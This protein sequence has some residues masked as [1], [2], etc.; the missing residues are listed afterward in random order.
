MGLKADLNDNLSGTL[1]LFDLT[2]TNVLTDDPENEGFSIQTGEQKSQGIEVSLN[3]ELKPGW[4]IFAGYTYTDA[5]VSQ[6]NRIP[7][8]NRLRNAPSNAFNIW[9]T[10]Q[11]Q[12]GNFDGLGFGFGVFYVGEREGDLANTFQLPSY[13]RT[14][15]AIYFE[16]SDLRAGLNFKNLFDVEYYESSF[17]GV[18]VFPGAPFTMEGNLSWQF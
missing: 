3:G 16:R 5:T 17:G 15:A 18:G 7:V 1:A 4:N 2:R 11:I 10:Y 14:D 8:G 12:E 6:D 9:T 13:L